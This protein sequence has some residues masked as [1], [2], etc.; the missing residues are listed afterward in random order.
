MCNQVIETLPT[1]YPMKNNILLLTFSLSFL[2]SFAQMDW[3]KI[4]E[5]PNANV[6]AISQMLDDFRQNH[7]D[8]KIPK[9]FLRWYERAY[10]FADEDGNIQRHQHIAAAQSFRRLHN[11]S[12]RA[13]NWSHVGPV[14]TEHLFGI[15]RMN[16]IVFHPSDTNIMYAG[17]ASGGLYKTMDHGLN[18]TTST[19]T[20]PALGVSDVAIHPHNPQIMYWATGDNDGNSSDSYGLLKSV[21]GGLSWTNVL[22]PTFGFFE[23]D[24][25]IIDPRHPD[26]VL[27]ACSRGV[28]RTTD[29][30]QNWNRTLTSEIEDLIFHP[31]NADTVYAVGYGGNNGFFRS[32]DNGQTWTQGGMGIPLGDV[33]N[34]LG[35]M[36]L[37]VTAAAPQYVYVLVIKNGSGN[38]N[39]HGVYRS[40]DAGATFAA[41]SELDP[42]L[43]FRQGWWD[44][45]INVDPIDP[46]LVYI[47]DWRL[48]KSTDGA[49][50]WTEAMPRGLHVDFHDLEFHPH[51]GDIWIANDGGI[52]HAPNQNQATSFDLR[53]EGIAA[54]QFYRLGTSVHD[55]QGILAGCQDNGTMEHIDGDW[56]RAGGG[57]GMEC[58]FSWED[59]D[60]Q[61]TSS[62]RGN[63]L[64]RQFGNASN[65]LNSNFTGETGA[66]VTPIIQDPSYSRTYYAGY[67]SVWKTENQA[68]WQNLSGSL[69]SGNA[70][71]HKILAPQISQ[72]LFVYAATRNVLFA[73]LDRGVNW[74]NKLL[75]GTMNDLAANAVQPLILYAACSNGVFKS[76]DAGDSWADISQGLPPTPIMSIVYQRGADEALYA[77]TT[78]G[79]YYRDSILNTWV[80]FMDGLPNVE[81]S[82]LEISYCAGKIRAATFGRG[83]WESDLYPNGFQPLEVQI[84]VDPGTDS[85][86]SRLTAIP[87]GGYGPFTYSWKNF[88]TTPSLENPRSGEYWVEVTDFNH[89]V[90]KDTAVLMATDIQGEIS[91]LKE[92]AIFPNP[93]TDVL[94]IRCY[95]PSPMA[96][97]LRIFNPLGQQFMGKNQHF[98]SGRHTYSW[99]ISGLKPGMYFLDMQVGDES[100]RYTLVK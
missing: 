28:Y 7:P 91:V 48:Y 26:T 4:I 63:I 38:Y 11:Q 15:G 5:D 12:S 77:G 96:G 25:I 43:N 8:K 93:V 13:A 75:P 98:F 84:D 24:E 17:S 35:R 62:Q 29:G 82:E 87:V 50:N 78:A 31:N 53:S 100:L 95:A 99:D 40:T 61:I 94:H 49:Q 10:A 58:L 69:L 56:Y 54:T 66:W 3:E 22:V 20:M 92:I 6:H 52:F 9:Q 83:M 23:M 33:T 57:D 21:D 14:S 81:I 85:M 74:V 45:L 80:P 79:V 68:T 30:G 72:G 97:R 76:T 19:D 2:F 51:T 18:W 86:N 47:A 89:C 34:N 88:K 90:A 42:N 27:V 36:M 67:Q 46:E 37:A 60:L 41:R 70:T 39:F 32:V 65:W 71:F 16:A 44:L 64:K 73:S 59:P 55:P 1:P